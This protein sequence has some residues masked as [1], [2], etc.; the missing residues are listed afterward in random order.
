MID[1]K[2]LIQCLKHDISCFEAEGKKVSELYLRV[3]DMLRMIKGQPKIGGWIPCSERM[4]ESEK[5][6]EITYVSK[7]WKTGEPLYFIARAFYEDGTMTT[8]TSSFN[9]DDTD[10]WEYDEEKDYH[11]IP[12]GWFESVS[13]AEEFGAV[14]MPVIAWREIAEPYRTEEEDQE[15]SEE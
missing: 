8:E 3:D 13:F 2:K 10:H 4:P 11:V 7:Q 12:E 1:E 9:W 14:D 15:V 5:D 6:V